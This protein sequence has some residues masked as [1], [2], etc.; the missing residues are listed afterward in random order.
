MRRNAS[1]RVIGSILTALLLLTAPADI[2]AAPVAQRQLE[3]PQSLQ[4]RQERVIREAPRLVGEIPREAVLFYSRLWPLH[5]KIRVAFDGSHPQLYAEIVELSKQWSEGTTIAFDFGFPNEFYRWSSADEEFKYPVRISFQQGASYSLMGTECAVARPNQTTTVL[6]PE[7]ENRENWRATVLHE[8]GHVLG[9]P[10][11]FS[12]PRAKVDFNRARLRERYG[13]NPEFIGTETSWTPLDPDPDSA[14][15][16]VFPAEVFESGEKSPWYRP[17]AVA[18]LSNYDRELARF[19][20]GEG[21]ARPIDGAAKLVSVT[22]EADPPDNKELPVYELQQGVHWQLIDPTVLVT[23]VVA[24]NY[25]CKISA[26]E[27]FTHPHG[28]VALRPNDPIGTGFLVGDSIVMTC[29]HVVPNA[30]IAGKV[31]ADF[32][33]AR[34]Q[35]GASRTRTVDLARIPVAELLYTSRSNDFSLLRLE[36]PEG[37]PGRTLK[38]Y[39]L[40]VSDRPREELYRKPLRVFLLQHPGGQRLQI[41][42]TEIA[43]LAILQDNTTELRYNTDTLGGSSGGPVFS[44]VGRVVGIHQ[45]PGP[46]AKRR[47][48]I[49]PTVEYNIGMPIERILVEI[50]DNCSEEI[51][52]ALGLK[53]PN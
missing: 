32:E 52:K 3:I 18:Q 30:E 4:A 36:A 5:S 25:S 29:N 40:N 16:F 33:W 11:A 8:L 44:H 53:K 23:I 15:N 42:I 49:R 6:P 34:S 13:F 28:K 26:S 38:Y 14:M 21:A 10:H 35:P 12:H 51:L 37:E 41:G 46:E 48:A 31:Y 1:R 7:G 39:D 20:Y 19:V 9:F 22:A 24:T 45:K 47:A 27:D 43:E 50:R 17:Q 2:Y